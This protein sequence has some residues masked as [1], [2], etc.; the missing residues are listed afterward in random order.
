[1]DDEVIADILKAALVGRASLGCAGMSAGK[2]VT[3]AASII[4]IIGNS[5]WM[6]QSTLPEGPTR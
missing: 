6:S 4:G 1:V 2:L 3:P 5:P